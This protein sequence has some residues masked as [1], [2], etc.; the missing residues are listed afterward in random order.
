MLYHVNLVSISKSESFEADCPAP[1][2]QLTRL[3]DRGNFS[4]HALVSIVRLTVE[5]NLVTSEHLRC[6]DAPASSHVRSATASI[7]SLLMVALYPV[8]VSVRHV[9]SSAINASTWNTGEELVCVPVRILFPRKT[10]ITSYHL[11]PHTI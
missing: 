11:I 10:C 7:V 6:P 9:F 1:L 8:S 5:T 2:P 3:K 4:S